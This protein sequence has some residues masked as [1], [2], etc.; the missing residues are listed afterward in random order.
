MI[1]MISLNKMHQKVLYVMVYSVK[2]SKK[3]K[4][5]STTTF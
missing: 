1:L 3:V 2:V 4:V 5:A